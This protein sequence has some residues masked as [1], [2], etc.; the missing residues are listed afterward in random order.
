MIWRGLRG[1]DIGGCDL[2]EVSPRY[3]SSGNT[4]LTGANLMFGMLSILPTVPY[5]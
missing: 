1:L 2:V 5:R 3:A 4:F